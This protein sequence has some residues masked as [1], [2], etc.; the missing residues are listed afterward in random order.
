[1][2]GIEEKHQGAIEA[3]FAYLEDATNRLGRKDWLAILISSLIGLALQVGL[4]GEG[5]REF[6]RFASHIVRQLL[7]QVLYLPYPH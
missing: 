1:M 6:L 4:Q 2:Q 5:T 3:R 7:G